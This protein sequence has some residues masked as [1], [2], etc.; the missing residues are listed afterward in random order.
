MTTTHQQVSDSDLAN[1]T[2]RVAGALGDRGERLAT[3]E[4]CTGGWIAKCLTDQSGSSAWFEYGYVSYGNNAKTAMLGVEPDLLERHGAVSREVAE[5]MVTGAQA[6]ASAGY[7]LAVT[8]IAGPDG[9]SAD[10]PV[11]TVWLAWAGP[12]GQPVCRVEH[13]S[14][15][16]EQIRRQTV[17]AALSGLLA[18]LE[19]T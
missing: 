12:D 17:Q 14:G 6:A 15:S 9:G 19:S 7:A 13:F 11:G 5:R 2:V 18:L 1:L 8:G 10:K 3:A 16:R 4:S